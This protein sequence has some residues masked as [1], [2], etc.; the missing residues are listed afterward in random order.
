MLSRY[1]WD[2][3]ASDLQSVYRKAMNKKPLT[4]WEMSTSMWRQGFVSS[5]SQYNVQGSF[6]LL[7][8]QLLVFATINFV[9]TL[10]SCF[11]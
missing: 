8:S 2:N 10:F 11:V 6:F 9:F 3:I 4:V 5:L 1:N 7:I